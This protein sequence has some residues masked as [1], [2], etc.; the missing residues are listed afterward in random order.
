MK[1]FL[2]GAR[3]ISN[4]DNNV[5][6]RLANISLNNM[7]ALVGDA[8][9]VDKA[10]QQFFDNIHYKNVIVYAMNGKARNN[11]GNWS[12]KNIKSIGKTTGFDYYATKDLKMAEDADYGFMVWNGKSKGA[13]N[14]IVNLL[15][16]NK[17]TLV[18]FV[19]DKRYY[20]ITNIN[21]LKNMAGN[22]DNEKIAWL[23]NY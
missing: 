11:V 10:V 5:K 19:P 22:F 15:R 1:V 9:G 20:T 6:D 12:V 21:D 17:K 2:A 3:S 16:L 14:N 18:Y 13:L 23:T 4:L 7:T 8:N